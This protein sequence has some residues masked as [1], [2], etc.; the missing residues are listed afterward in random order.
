[1]GLKGRV[2]DGH[3]GHGWGRGLPASRRAALA[4]AC[5]SAGLLGVP[6]AAQAHPVDVTPPVIDGTPEVGQTLTAS[7]GSWRDPTSPVISYQYGWMLCLAGECQFDPSATT[8]YWR[9]PEEALAEEVAVVVTATDEDGESEAAEAQPTPIITYTGPRYSVAESVTGSGLVRGF[10]AGRADS[11]LLCA[12]QCSSYPYVPGTSIELIAEPGLGATFLGWG[13]ACSG[14]TPTCSFTASAD[15]SV[16]ARFTSL[17]APPLEA[18]SGQGA[19]GSTAGA[20]ALGGVPALGGGEAAA[21]PG[22]RAPA[23]LVSLRARRGRVEAVAACE[24]A[25]ACHLSLAVLSGRRTLARHAFT[26]PA[27][28]SVGVALALDG[29]GGRLLARR[30][31]HLTARLALSAGGRW[32]TVASRRL[33]LAEQ[34]L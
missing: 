5:V 22:G 1:M 23:R 16:S 3:A 4:L 27:W 13:G 20:P 26:V 11:T 7:P 2:K 19:P 24:R 17:P 32:A 21:L 15:T 18:G 10:A 30:R 14:T 12:S 6:R 8:S 28:S 31:L 25:S 29:A 9:L 34:A 33:T